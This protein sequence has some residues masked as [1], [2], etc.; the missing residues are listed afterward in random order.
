MR[1][2]INGRAATKEDIESGN[3]IFYIEGSR[4][5]HYPLGRDLPLM[6]R[7]IKSDVGEEFPPPGTSVTIFQ[8]EIS[9]GEHVVLG[10]V[11]GEDEE[12]ICDLG[13]VELLGQP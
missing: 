13:D 10:V 2:A 1:Q 7:V 8:A 12:A 9:D 6:A 11:Y 3:A 5:V 4:S